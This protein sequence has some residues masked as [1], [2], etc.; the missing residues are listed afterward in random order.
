ME[1]IHR[2]PEE[3]RE[4]VQWVCWKI[5]KRKEKGRV[6]KI[7]VPFDPKNGQPAPK[8]KDMANHSY[9]SLW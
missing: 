7:K 1:M 6:K 5:V 9:K 2:I 4:Y 3:L 8:H